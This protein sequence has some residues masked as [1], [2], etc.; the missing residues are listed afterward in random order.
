MYF[1][2]RRESGKNDGAEFWPHS[3]HQ[4]GMNTLLE[5]VGVALPHHE[6]KYRYLYIRIFDHLLP[7]CVNHVHRMIHLPLGGEVNPSK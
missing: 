3:L 6:K 4:P 5:I 7:A 1:I 2:I